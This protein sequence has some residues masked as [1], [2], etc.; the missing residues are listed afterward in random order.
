MLMKTL[1]KR[2]VA[3]NSLKMAAPAYRNFAIARYHFD[4][5]DYEPT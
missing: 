3:L 5:K 4:E 2:A 1:F